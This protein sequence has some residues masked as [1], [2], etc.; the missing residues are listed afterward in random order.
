VPRI[1]HILSSQIPSA[2][3]LRGELVQEIL[4]RLICECRRILKIIYRLIHCNIRAL[5]I[6]MKRVFDR[7]FLK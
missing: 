2:V 4:R 1:D 5:N 3:D 7:A 6:A